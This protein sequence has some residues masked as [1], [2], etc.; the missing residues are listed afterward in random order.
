MQNGKNNS[1]FG[2]LWKINDEILIQSN[3]PCNAVEEAF[4]L[5]THFHMVYL[6]IPWYLKESIRWDQTREGIHYISSL[7]TL[8]SEQLSE[9][10]LGVCTES[11]EDHGV[12][13]NGSGTETF[14][15][16]QARVFSALMSGLS[17]MCSGSIPVWP[18]TQCGDIL[19]TKRWDRVYLHR[20]AWQANVIPEKWRKPRSCW[21]CLEEVMLFDVYGLVW[22]LFLWFCLE[23]QFSYIIHLGDLT[24]GYHTVAILTQC[25]GGGPLFLL[26]FLA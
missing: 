2:G 20:R 3:P 11:R 18:Q 10:F 15:S 24:R 6:L 14:Q 13:W 4:H 26:S 7:G 19:H 16:Y 21:E 17:S 22:N 23:S 5:F 12:W 25:G 9:S 1:G 8:S